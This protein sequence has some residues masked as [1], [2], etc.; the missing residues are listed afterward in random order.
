VIQ[1]TGLR[2]V[3]V[4]ADGYGGIVVPVRH[5]SQPTAK[6]REM[7]ELLVPVA[8]MPIATK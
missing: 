1:A 8:L 7:K 3:H 2:W 5:K 4:Q 6:L